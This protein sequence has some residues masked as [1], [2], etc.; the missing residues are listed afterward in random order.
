MLRWTILIGTFV[1]WLACMG[2][3]YVHCKPVARKDALPSAQASLEALFEEDAELERAWRVFVDPREL[4]TIGKTDGSAPVRPPWSGVDEKRLQEVGWFKTIYKK[5]A[6]DTSRLEQLTEAEITIPAE[7]NMPVLQML[8]TLKYRN[9][10][11]ISLDTGLESFN[12]EFNMGLGF[13]VISLGVRDGEYLTVTQQIFQNQ[14]KLHDQKQ[15]IMVGTKG[16]PT[17]ELMPFQPNPNIRK[18]VTWEIAML[19][20][21]TIDIAGSSPPQ[22]QMLKVKCVGKRAISYNNAPTMSY[23]VKTSDGKTRAWYS[24]DGVVLKQA[25]RLADLIEIVVVRADAKTF[26][27]S[28]SPQI[29][30][31]PR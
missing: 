13:K 24:A 6:G 18:D 21:N 31:T 12:S 2:L 4:Q 8:G 10:S 16:T 26:N 22:L 20:T 15:K 9:R 11:D 7:A 25:F 29:I 19:D 3:V 28:G 23:E 30:K 5:R 1:V 14:N 27:T 17:L